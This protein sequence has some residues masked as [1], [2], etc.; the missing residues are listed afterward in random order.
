MLSGFWYTPKEREE[1]AYKGS[2]PAM[3]P[4][5]FICCIFIPPSCKHL[6]EAGMV[7]WTPQAHKTR[8]ATA[9]I[10]N[11]KA[12]QTKLYPTPLT[13]SCNFT[14]KSETL[15]FLLPCCLQLCTLQTILTTLWIRDASRWAD[16]ILRR[17]FANIFKQHLHVPVLFRTDRKNRC[18]YS[19]CDESVE[20]LATGH[21]LAWMPFNG[22]W[23]DF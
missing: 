20:L 15:A 17:F 18:L 5:S 16:A 13:A 11:A 21:G 3:L 7:P 2:I 12:V 14:K 23:T 4:H 1:Q 10:N 8:W 6:K 9:T 22:D 19:A